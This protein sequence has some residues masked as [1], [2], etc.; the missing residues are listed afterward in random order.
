[1]QLLQEAGG[2]S[3]TEADALRADIIRHGDDAKTLA[4]MGER[5]VAGAADATAARA[6]W[7]AA[8][9]FAAYSFSRA[10]AAS[11]ALI[12]MQ[13]TWLRTHAAAELGC[14]LLHLYGGMYPLRTIAAALARDGVVLLGPSVNASGAAPTVERGPAGA[15]VRIGL[16]A[17]R[18]VRRGTIAAL[19]AARAER[20]FRDVPDL[21]RRMRLQPRELEALVLTG[22]FDMLPPLTPEAY[23]F[24]HDALI[25]VLAREANP[26]KLAER[27]R[28]VTRRPAQG[29]D[30]ERLD[31]Y[32]RLVRV[33]N[34]IQFLDVHVSDHPMRLLRR[35]AAAMGCTP[36]HELI[37]HAD[38]TVRVAGI[39]AASRRVETRAGTTMKFLTLE[40]EHGTVEIVLLPPA[41]LRVAERITTPGPYLV[42][43]RVRVE[44]DD[45]SITASD[46]SAFHERG[47]P[48][49]A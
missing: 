11:Y 22:A 48:G 20:R 31:R 14:A 10:H 44:Q 40:D 26:D 7:Q 5:F 28:R 39:L 6:A 23:P 12:A 2:V 29:T 47:G 24:V 19:L 18:R 13:V 46:V 34:E 1:M 9:R 33:R 17:I 42:T 4:A 36:T 3:L 15:A 16:G 25:A 21:L 37:A 35:D 41:L 30:A 43:G 38:H 27:L 45:V 32:R 49:A 8:T